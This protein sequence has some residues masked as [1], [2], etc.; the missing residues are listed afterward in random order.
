MPCI[1][2]NTQLKLISIFF[3][4]FIDTIFK[5]PLNV[6]SQ[7][8][9]VN[10]TTLVTTT[11]NMVDTTSTPPDD[12][13][14]S[15]STPTQTNLTTEAT[16][17]GNYTPNSSPNSREVKSDS[18]TALTESTKSSNTTVPRETI[19]K[20]HRTLWALVVFVTVGLLVCLYLLYLFVRF[21][22]F[23]FQQ[24]WVNKLNMKDKQ[25]KPAHSDW[26][27]DIYY[28]GEIK[29]TLIGGIVQNQDLYALI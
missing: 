23:S 11:N 25:I 18:T 24:S 17:R 21:Q 2:K 28:L 16:A 9:S 19:F 4:F 6:L 10:T 8:T 5:H 26:N 29:P 20:S 12:T 3:K 7:T 1:K 22:T 15:E 27:L 13:F 14:S